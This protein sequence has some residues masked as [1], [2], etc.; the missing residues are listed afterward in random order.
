VLI[1]LRLRNLVSGMRGVVGRETHETS[2]E[3]DDMSKSGRERYSKIV[4]GPGARGEVIMVFLTP[5]PLLGCTLDHIKQLYET[6]L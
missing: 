5:V 1:D 2:R 3:P 4:R 6:V